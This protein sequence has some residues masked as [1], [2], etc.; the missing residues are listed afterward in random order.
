MPVQGFMRNINGEPS[1]VVLNSRVFSNG[2]L[3]KLHDVEIQFNVRNRPRADRVLH[4]VIA[5]Q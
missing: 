1:R 5:E 3:M 4:T 2:E